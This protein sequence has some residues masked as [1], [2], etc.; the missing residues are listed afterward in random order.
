MPYPLGTVLICKMKKP[1]TSFFFFIKRKHI[2][3]GYFD[4]EC[5]TV[6]YFLLVFGCLLCWLHCVTEKL[7]VSFS[8]RERPK[9]R[10]QG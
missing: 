5:N 4:T 9:K 1:V 7:E 10:P 6:C 8:K 3:Y 2:F